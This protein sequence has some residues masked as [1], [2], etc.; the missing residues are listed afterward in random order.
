[1]VLLTNNKYQLMMIT[2][3]EKRGKE[4]M[5]IENT[6]WSKELSNNGLKE[7]NKKRNSNKGRENNKKELDLLE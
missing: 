4:K 5:L 1:M 7:S 2:K 6:K 3:E